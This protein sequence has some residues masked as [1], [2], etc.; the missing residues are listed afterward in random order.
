L[1]DVDDY[2]NYNY[3]EMELFADFSKKIS[4]LEKEL[5]KDIFSWER[6]DAKKI[7]SG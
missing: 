7:V 2:N 1:Q 4:A 6:K 3:Q 5:P